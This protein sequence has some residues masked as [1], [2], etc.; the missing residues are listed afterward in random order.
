MNSAKLPD[1]IANVLR[2]RWTRG[3]FDR[4]AL[5]IVDAGASEGDGA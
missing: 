2:E 3:D 4:G 1:H 5:L